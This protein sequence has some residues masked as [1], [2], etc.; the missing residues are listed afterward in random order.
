[1]HDVEVFRPEEPGKI[2]KKNSHASP[3]P[4]LEG[5]NIYVHFGTH[6]TA[7]LTSAGKI[8]WKTNELKYTRPCMAREVRR[9]WLT[10]C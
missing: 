9:C 4:I 3:T 7:C 6:G 5:E 8:V 10:I 1:M 2:H